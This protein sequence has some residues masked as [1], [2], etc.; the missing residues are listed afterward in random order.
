MQYI[1]IATSNVKGI[2]LTL[3]LNRI[4]IN[5]LFPFFFFE[6]GSVEYCCIPYTVFKRS[7][8]TLR[9]LSRIR[10]SSEKVDKFNGG[11]KLLFIFFSV[12]SIL[13]CLQFSLI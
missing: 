2:V 8:V 10:F 3:F 13:V 1:N 5:D 12:V 9:K 6:L 4:F 7:S 11:R